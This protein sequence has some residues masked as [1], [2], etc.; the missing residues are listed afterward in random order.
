MKHSVITDS[1][2]LAKQIAAVSNAPYIA[3]DTEFMRER[4][5]FPILCLVQIAAGDIAFA[6]DPLAEDID[7]SPLYALLANEKVIKVFHS[8][9]QDIE[10]FYYATGSTPKSVFDTQVAAEVLGY[11][12]SASYATLV[13][14]ICKVEIDKSSR[15]TDWM[16]RPLSSAQ[17]EYALSDVT[18]LCDVYEKLSSDLVK[19]ER[20]HWTEEEMTKLLDPAEYENAPQDAWRW[21]KTRG[22]SQKFL[23]AVKAIAAWREEKAKLENVPRQR[24]LRDEILLEVAAVDPKSVEELKGMRRLQHVNVSGRLGEVLIGLLN[25]ARASDE[26][27]DVK[28]EPPIHPSPALVELLKVL[29]KAECET[30]LV[31]Q[32]LVARANDI[33]KIAALDE[34]ILQ[35]SADIKCMQGWRFDVFGKAALEL[36]KG[37]LLLGAKKNKILIVPNAN[38]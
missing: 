22:G 16:R 15:F 31:T 37:N 38:S 20:T 30:H 19:K 36:K 13:K 8:A 26:V 12:E 1:K 2:T 32:K 24:I 25:E 29:L 7:L 4:T 6:I 33:D 34:E 3:I 18:Y 21:I 17:I 28:K 11:G 27:L 14:K 5:Y 10:L 35:Q 23:R 9:S